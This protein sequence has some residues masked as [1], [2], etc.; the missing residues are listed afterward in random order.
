VESQ[1]SVPDRKGVEAY[2]TDNCNS[3]RDGLGL[4]SRLKLVTEPCSHLDTINMVAIF[5]SCE[6]FY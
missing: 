4:N 6:G 3:S 5:F 2:L 1:R